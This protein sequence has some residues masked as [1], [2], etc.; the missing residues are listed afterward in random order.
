MKKFPDGYFIARAD[1]VPAGAMITLKTDYDLNNPVATW[2]EISKVLPSYMSGKW[3]DP[4]SLDYGVL[5]YWMNP[6]R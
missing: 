1:G 6:N 2:E 4:E 3:S 5:M